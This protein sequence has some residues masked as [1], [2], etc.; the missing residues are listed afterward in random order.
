VIG[1]NRRLIVCA[2]VI[3]PSDRTELIEQGASD[4]IAPRSRSAL[5]VAERI[6]AEII[7][8]GRVQ[9]ASC[10][11]IIGA[12]AVMRRLYEEIELL[13]PNPKPIL[14]LGDPGVG[15]ELTARALHE[16]SGRTGAFKPINCAALPAELIESE[17]F[18][19]TGSAFTGAK[20]PRPGLFVAADKG[21][22]FLDEIGDLPL[23]MQPKLLRVLQEGMV[24]PVGADREQAV[25][26]RVVTA[27][28]RD[29]WN[30]V[31]E[32]RFR[33]DLY[34]R[35]ETHQLILPP[36]CERMADLPLLFNHFVKKFNSG[37]N[38]NL[39]VSP[40]AFD[41]LFRFDWPGN[42]RQLESVVERASLRSDPSSGLIS[43][44]ILWNAIRPQMQSAAKY[45]VKFDPT[46]DTWNDVSKR[47]EK[48]Y[49]RAVDALYRDNK[50]A[51]IERS[52]L[53]RS[54]YYEKLK[55]IRKSDGQVE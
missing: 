38:V 34:W 37:N 22:I 33:E 42:I 52:G 43:E 23:M 39:K 35:L 54:Q 49:F 21:T 10:R 41:C 26:V 14:I 28:N 13:A 15:K 19:H 44:G 8:A 24:R 7:L 31:S 11:A 6:L 25:Q 53:S 48:S 40:D 55:A 47:A 9:P 12:T 36:L 45:S 16:L 5:H 1:E 51:A 18:G 50:A 46:S 27:T 30:E 4:V 20:Q 17:L 29:L 32:G 3:S 2:P